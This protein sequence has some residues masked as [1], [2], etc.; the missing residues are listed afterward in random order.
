[1]DTPKKRDCQNSCDWPNCT[2]P[3]CVVNGN[4]NDEWN[5]AIDMCIE[6]LNTRVEFGYLEA[7]WEFVKR[8]LERLKR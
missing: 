7:K 1:M 2:L 5:G 4:S 8:E 6:K 3:K